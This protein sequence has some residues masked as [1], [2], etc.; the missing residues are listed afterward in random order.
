MAKPAFIYAFDN[1]GPYRFTE[2]CG[3]LFGS[4]YNGFMLGG[5]G[6]DGGVDGEID[7]ELGIWHPE[8]KEPLLNEIIQPGQTVVFQFKHK[9]SARVGQAQTRIQLLN[10]FKCGK[11]KVCELHSKLIQEKKPLSYVLV[12]NVEVNSQF[13]DTF[14]NQCKA[15]NPDIQNYQIIG[16]DELVSW[17]EMMPELR[18]L[19]F[20]TIFGIPRFDLRINISHAVSILNTNV[21][22]DPAIAISVLNVGSVSSYLN[23][24]SIR[25]LFI[26][27]GKQEG[28]TLYLGCDAL[29][30]LNPTS[31][32]KLEP[33]RSQNYFLPLNYLASLEESIENYY[34]TSEKIFPTEV[35]VKDEI[36]NRYQGLLT[37]D[38]RKTI[39][40]YIYGEQV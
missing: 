5:I 24:N 26:L 2:L 36:S 13:R 27:K 37:D 18:Q 40:K 1:L 25:L 14:I 32:V 7:T 23:E 29:K 9:V 28:I 21:P 31:T 4:R 30:F 20:P 15:E 22:K 6:A 16:L 35:Q 12:T 8:S 33:G 19:Y 3:D 39:L 17:I 10:L 34:E 38:F 11:T